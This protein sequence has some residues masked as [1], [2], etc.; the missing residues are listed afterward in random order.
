MFRDR[1]D[2]GRQLAE[3]LSRFGGSPGAVVYGIP[4]GGVV[5]AA[6]VASILGLPL[7]IVVVRKIG[8]P[9]NPEYAVGAVDQDGN[10]MRNPEARVS[11]DY[12]DREAPMVRAEIERRIAAYRQGSP[13]VPVHGKTAIIVDDG[14][15]TGLTARAAVEFLRSHGAASVVLAVPVI[16]RASAEDLS[17]VV[18]DLIAVQTPPSFYAVGQFYDVFG[19]TTDD[20]VQR[21]LN[22]RASGD[23]GPAIGT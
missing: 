4:R 19:Q 21:L 7:D 15:A 9:A 16:S 13:E 2:A 6:E 17:S 3:K 22:A 12:L 23:S 18:D 1:V 11:S 10:V 20:E 14:I 5:V 8:A